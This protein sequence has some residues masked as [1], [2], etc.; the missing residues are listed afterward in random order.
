[1]NESQSPV[2]LGA[3]HAA[4]PTVDGC[5]T[6]VDI[7]ADLHPGRKSPAADHVFK[8]A[9]GDRQALAYITFLQE[10][11]GLVVHIDRLDKEA[12]SSRGTRFSLF[13]RFQTMVLPC[14][15]KMKGSPLLGAGLR[16]LFWVGKIRLF[17]WRLTQNLT[18]TSEIDCGRLRASSTKSLIYLGVCVWFRRRFGGF[19]H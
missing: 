14:S 2:F 17:D 16:F 18:S 7:L 10:L 9:V 4:N 6:P 3:E 11:G 15:K 8:A 13:P 19:C 1:M 5:G 12:K